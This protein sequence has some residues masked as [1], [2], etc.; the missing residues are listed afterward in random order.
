MLNTSI[1]ESGI[2]G[3][4]SENPCELDNKNFSHTQYIEPDP[5]N[6]QNPSKK[7][8][9]MCHAKTRSEEISMEEHG[10]MRDLRPMFGSGERKRTRD[11]KITEKESL[12]ILRRFD[13]YPFSRHRFQLTPNTCDNH[14]TSKPRIPNICRITNVP[15][16]EDNPQLRSRLPPEV[17]NHLRS[18]TLETEGKEL[19]PASISYGSNKNKATE[20][21]TMDCID[22]LACNANMTIRSA[23]LVHTTKPILFCLDYCDSEIGSD[24]EEETKTYVQPVPV[25]EL[26]EV[27]KSGIIAEEE[28]VR[29]KCKIQKKKEAAKK[30]MATIKLQPGWNQPGDWGVTYSRS[31]NIEKKLENP[32]KTKVANKK[33][34]WLEK[35]T[36]LVWAKV[37][38]G[39]YEPSLS[40]LSDKK[41]LV[42]A[43]NSLRG[44][45]NS[46]VD[47]LQE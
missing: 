22:P 27:V 16:T 10:I 41:S 44:E 24:L 15:K 36:S 46:A 43:S 12:H 21:G 25:E 11:I 3:V 23:A 9:M 39:I 14:E 30:L 20:L 28:P 42:D 33:S 13:F 2:P 19:Q 17:N 37:Q 26:K 47:T 32:E 45:N 40:I 7:E 8:R 31:D 34:S 35:F 18:E 1:T 29:E 38:E 4:V 5:R 6:P